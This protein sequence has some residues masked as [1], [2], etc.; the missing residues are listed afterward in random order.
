MHCVTDYPVDDIYANLK[1]IN[2]LKK[3]LKL[4]VGYSDHTRGIIAPLVAVAYGAKVVEKHLT[5][6]K[7]MPGPDHIASLDLIEFYFKKY[8]S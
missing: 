5:L 7:K 6:N 1:A 8:Y 4:D 2:Y 3:K